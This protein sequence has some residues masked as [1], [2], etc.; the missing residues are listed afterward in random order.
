MG[1]SRRPPVMTSLQVVFWG[2]GRVNVPSVMVTG[3]PMLP[4]YCRGK[5]VI[6][7]DIEEHVFSGTTP[8]WRAGDQTDK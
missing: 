2:L 7:P 8:P 5:K 3:G 6:T 1:W 4:G